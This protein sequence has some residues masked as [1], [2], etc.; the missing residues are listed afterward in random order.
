MFVKN[1]TGVLKKVLLSKP[2]YLKAAPIN[3]IARK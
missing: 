3:E 1:G 2:Q